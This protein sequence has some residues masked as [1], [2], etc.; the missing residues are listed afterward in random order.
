[1]TIDGFENKI[2]V[3]MYKVKIEISWECKEN[4]KQKRNKLQTLP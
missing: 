3:Y 4:K 2:Y 1:M